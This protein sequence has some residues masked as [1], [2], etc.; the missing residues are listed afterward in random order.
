MNPAPLPDAS[1]PA[2]GYVRVSTD[3]QARDDRTSLTQ[4]RQAIDALALRSGLALV[5]TFEDPG[6]SGGRAENRPG[7]M[8]LEAYCKAHPRPT[9]SPGTVLVLND[10]RW[11]RFDDPEEATWWRFELKKRYGWIVRFAEADESG[12]S[13]VRGITRFMHQ[14]QATIYRE[15]IKA[16]A[17]R[18]ARGTAALGFWQNEA[19]IGYR[20]E[21]IDSGTGQRRI[22][23]VGQRKGGG[24]RV[25]LTPGPAEEVALI[26]WMMERYASGAVS[27]GALVRELEQR[28]P[29]RAWSRATANAVLRNPAYVG[30]VIWC[31]RPHDAEERLESAVRPKAEWVIC[32]DAHPPLITRDLFARV[33]A[34]RSANG[35]RRQAA[36]SE[37]LLTGVLTCAHCGQPYIGSGGPKGPPTDPDR[38]RF[39]RDRG[40]DRRYGGCPGQLGTLQRRIIEPKVIEAIAKVVSQPAVQEAIGRA[41]DAA[42]AAVLPDPDAQ[43]AQRKAEGT[44]IKLER[45]R[46]VDAVARQLLSDEE[47][48]DRIATLRARESQL[49]ADAERQRFASQRATGFASERNSLMKLAADFSTV[50]KRL[51]GSALRELV[52]PW[53]ASATVDKHKR[54][55]TLRIRQ[56]PGIGLFSVMGGSP[57]RG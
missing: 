31:R 18:G 46:L 2:I 33:E 7:F 29:S 9:R 10:S 5:A 4:Q 28:W 45:E 38:Y 12:D 55:L 56:V 25:R 6:A 43:R 49:E 19:P 27:L 50:A 51:S 16:N 13:L 24:E 52:R 8:A 11:G 48:R 23:N 15:A 3:E 53:L 17:K 1:S 54:T 32:R 44:R 26:G 37:Y 20:R 41:F 36:P 39:Y 57:G 47:V 42:S 35:A 14:S 21:A 22:L 40:G 30:D 34:Q